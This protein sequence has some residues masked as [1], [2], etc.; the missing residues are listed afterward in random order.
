VKDTLSAFLFDKLQHI[1]FYADVIKDAIDFGQKPHDTSFLDVG[2]GPGLG[3]IYAASQ[4][5]DALGFDTNPKSIQK[6]V[7]YAKANNVRFECKE[8][9][10]EQAFT[11]FAASLLA[12]FE[13]RVQGA[14]KL[15]DAVKDG[16]ILIIVEP[17]KLMNTS[18]AALYIKNHRPKRA[19]WLYLWAFAR[20]RNIVDE[21]IF[22]ALNYKNL[23]YMP[24]M[25]GLIGVWKIKK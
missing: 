3:A 22:S 12:V 20:Q 14:Q 24:L 1:E 11:V 9:G 6:A 4:G 18:N 16:G 13:D 21:K 10:G 25:D 2:C 7:G 8:L 19:F 15:F 17:T 23:E 5:Y